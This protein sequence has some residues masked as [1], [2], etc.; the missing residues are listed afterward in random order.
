M[1]VRGRKYASQTSPERTKVWIEPHSKNHAQLQ[2]GKK[3]PVVY[4]L[5]RNRHLEHP[6]FMEVPLSSSD[7]LYLRDVINRLNALRGKGM[8]AL[9]SWSCKRSYKNGFV[10]H[11]LSEDDLVLPAHGNEYILKGSELLDQSPQERPNNI[12][13]NIKKEIL[14]NSQID[15]PKRGGSHEASSSSS[16]PPPCKEEKKMLVRDDDQSHVGTAPS[17]PHSLSS[18]SSPSTME[19]R[20]IKPV[21]AHDASTQ[22]EERRK[23]VPVVPIPVPVSGQI[24]SKKLS[25]EIVRDPPS[26]APNPTYSNISS[27]VTGS[28]TGSSGRIDTLESLIRAEASKRNNFRVV[29][30]EEVFSPEDERLK[31][32]NLLLQIVTCGSLAVKDHKGFGLVPTYRPRFTQIGF[33]SPVFSTLK[34][35]DRMSENTRAV[36]LRVEEAEYYSGSMIEGKK[37][38]EDLSTGSGLR[39]STSFEDER[40]YKTTPD[41]K[42]DAKHVHGSTTTKCLPQTIKMISCKQPRGETVKSPAGPESSKLSP[43]CSSNG[44]SKRTMTDSSSVAGSTSMRIESFKADKEKIIKIEESLLLEL[45]L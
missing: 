5:C 22:T 21:E 24:R 13:T 26:P 9:Y 6:H 23:P 43:L 28:A 8:A 10:W 18:A 36:G 39:R 37:H 32:A 31:P 33:P 15:S 27:S 12:S 2:Q 35:L 38:R 30:E 44:V 17:T 19:Y 25:H 14:K 41:S 7:G 16:S 29:E 34:D 1:E 45:G 4:Y 20:V 42:R 40:S 11:D 3:V